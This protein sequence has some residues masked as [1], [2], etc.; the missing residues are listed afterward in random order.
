MSF[1]D[2]FLL[3]VALCNALTKPASKG[4]RN[5]SNS[6]KTPVVQNQKFEFKKYLVISTTLQDYLK[7]SIQYGA[8]E[9]CEMITLPVRKGAKI[10]P[11]KSLHVLAQYN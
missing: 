3:F 11:A 10:G 2:L 6:V 4:W 9:I 7:F 1:C 5:V 8:V